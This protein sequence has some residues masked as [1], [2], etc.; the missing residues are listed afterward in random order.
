MFSQKT[1]LKTHAKK[2]CL[3]RS[4]ISYILFHPDFNR[5]LWHLTRSA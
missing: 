1:A 4:V 3:W 5:R 2:L